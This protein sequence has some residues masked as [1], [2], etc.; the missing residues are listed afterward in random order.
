M[1]VRVQYSN[2]NVNHYRMKM[3]NLSNSRNI[4]NIDINIIEII[5]ISLNPNL[6]DTYLIMNI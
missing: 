6:I 1:K 4:C 2:E 3:S 5:C